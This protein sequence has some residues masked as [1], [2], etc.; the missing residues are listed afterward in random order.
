MRREYFPPPTW[1]GGQALHIARGAAKHG[2][3]AGTCLKAGAQTKF[4]NRLFV[5]APFS[6]EVVAFPFFPC[7]LEGFLQSKKVSWPFLFESFVCGH[8]KIRPCNEVGASEKETKWGTREKIENTMG[9]ERKGGD[10][11]ILLLSH[12]SP[13]TEKGQ[14]EKTDERRN[15]CMPREILKRK[16]FFSRFHFSF[17]KREA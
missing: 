5:H 14:Q 6:T 12:I 4:Q 13:A 11:Q 3:V 15:R 2:Y 9:R 1:K 7:C 8:T 10:E 16:S 17:F